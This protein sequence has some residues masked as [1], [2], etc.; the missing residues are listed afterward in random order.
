[1]VSWKSG[2]GP[3]ITIF[4]SLGSVGLSDS[5]AAIPGLISTAVA[6]V[7]R[8]RRPTRNALAS[9]QILCV[10]PLQ[11]AKRENEIGYRD[12]PPMVCKQSYRFSSLLWRPA[13]FVKYQS[14]QLYM[15]KASGR[16]GRKFKTF[17]AIANKPFIGFWISD[18]LLFHWVPLQRSLKLTRD[19]C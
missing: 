7:V 9:L 2:A 18:E 15:Q 14:K 5:I 16:L 3:R 6:Y 12:N 4:H 8:S 19:I 10:D 1:M 17:A 13:D 11:S